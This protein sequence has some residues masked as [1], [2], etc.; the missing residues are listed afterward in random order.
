MFTYIESRSGHTG[1][2]FTRPATLTAHKFI[3]LQDNRETKSLQPDEDPID[4]VYTANQ[5]NI[6]NDKE[7][8]C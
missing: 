3:N 6:T 7:G 2:G 4:M 5:Y 1:V 8:W